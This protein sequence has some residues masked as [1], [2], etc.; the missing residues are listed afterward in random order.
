MVGGRRKHN[1]RAALRAGDSW[2]IDHDDVAGV[3]QVPRPRGTGLAYSS[4]NAA[5]LPVLF[6]PA[7]A[8]LDERETRLG[9]ILAGISKRRVSP[10]S[11]AR[12]QNKLWNS[13]CGVISQYGIAFPWA[14]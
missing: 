14:C 10:G 5:I 12:V 2:E 13:S 1:G 3:K 4:A 7:I 11:S 6:S 9:F 8:L